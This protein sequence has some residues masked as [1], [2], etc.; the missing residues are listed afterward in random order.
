MLH[1]ILAL[2]AAAALCVVAADCDAGAPAAGDASRSATASSPAP[3]PTIA[4]VG[5][6]SADDGRS[7]DPQNGYGG[8]LT[9]KLAISTLKISQRGDRYVGVI[10]TPALAD[11][12]PNTLVLR[13][14]SSAG[15]TLL[16]APAP[17]T[18]ITLRALSADS[19]SYVVRV[20]ANGVWTLFSTMTFL[21]VKSPG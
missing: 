21:R 5:R 1:T 17:L 20:R 15:H 9:F 8:P 13:Q 7:V 3:D 4:W 14:T 16:A 19:F 2:V 18:R 6:Y 10:A 11:L 12:P